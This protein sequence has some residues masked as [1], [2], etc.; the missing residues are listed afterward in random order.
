MNIQSNEPI[1]TS[2]SREIPKS[3]LN[4]YLTRSRAHPSQIYTTIKYLK[5]SFS[6]PFLKFQNQIQSQQNQLKTQ[7]LNALRTGKR[8]MNK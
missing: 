2:S 6:I 3:K 1:S 7:T 5:Y 8:Q 4:F